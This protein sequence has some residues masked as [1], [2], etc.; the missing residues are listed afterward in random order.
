MELMDY[1]NHHHRC[2]HALGSIEDYIK[3]A[4]EK[5]L[6]EIGIADHFPFGAI[7]DEEKYADLIKTISMK[8]ADFPDYIQEIKDLREKYKGE[9]R[10]KISTE[11]GFVTSGIHLDQQKKILEPFMDDFDYLLC[12]V[13]ELKFDGL[14]IVPLSLRIDPN[15]LKI[16]GE[17]KIHHEYIKKMKSMVETGYFDICTH[18]D[19]HKLLWLP[20]EPT[21]SETA[22]QEMMELLDLIKAKGMAVEI[23]TSGTWKGAHSQYPSD[24]IVKE[25]IQ[26]EIPLT[27]SSDAHRPENIGYEFEEFI[28]KA[29]PWGLTHLCAFEKREQRLIP[30]N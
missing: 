13:H 4:I 26:R 18:L 20:E 30:I 27:L 10:V 6:S 28:K 24:N 22:W 16:H 9:I 11:V 14:P 29:K 17:D 25:M 19:N 3:D 15:T 23:N 8:V 1:H 5:N 7:A 21:Y 12:G 2:G